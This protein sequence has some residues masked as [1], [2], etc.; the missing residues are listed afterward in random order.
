MRIGEIDRVRA[1][2]AR[3]SRW[4]DQQ[5]VFWYRFGFVLVIWLFRFWIRRYRAIGAEHVPARGGAFLVANHTSGMDPFIL[6]CPIRWRMLRGP[7]K[8]ELFANPLFG[9]FMRKIGMF[10]LRQNVADA[11]AVRTMVEV[12]RSGKVV[13]VYP[14]GGR[15]DDGRLQPFSADFARLIIRLRAPIV[16]AGI[17]GGAQLLPIGSFLPRPGTPVVV[18]YG[19]PY[20][21]AEFYGQKVGVETA[22]RAAAIMRD[23][24][25]ELMRVAEEERSRMLQAS[26]VCPDA[27][28]SG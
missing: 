18:V 16:P 23:R 11:A 12:Y 10:P 27:R 25:A 20:E 17:A 7:G 19:E 14:E 26:R 6:G 28:S 8:E 2:R 21:L 9:Y 4:V 13:V 5:S 24:V 1:P 15:S 22:E 3:S